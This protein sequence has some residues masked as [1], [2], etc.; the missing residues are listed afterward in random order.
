MV[1]MAGGSHQ[2]LAAPT[3]WDVAG[4]QDLFC[5]TKQAVLW[6]VIEVWTNAQNSGRGL[7]IAYIGHYYEKQG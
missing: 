1:M 7:S 6:P 5:S 2:N 3:R 4:Y